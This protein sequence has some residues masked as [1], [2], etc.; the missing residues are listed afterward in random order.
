M[1]NREQRINRLPRALADRNS[2]VLAED[3]LHLALESCPRKSRPL[4]L[5][6]KQNNTPREIDIREGNVRGCRRSA[7]AVALQAELRP[8]II[9]S[10]STST[11]SSFSRDAPDQCTGMVLSLDCLP[12]EILHSILCYC[13]PASAAAL[14]Q[15]ARRFSSITDDPILWRFYCQAYFQL[16]DTKHELPKKL[17]SPVASVDWKTLYTR[18]HRID[19]QV[20]RLLDSILETEHGRIGKFQ[21]VIAFGYDTQDT[22]LR[23]ASVGPGAEDV[24]ARRF[25]LDIYPW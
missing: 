8:A 14:A 3:P 10:A 11:A 2:L 25:A 13:P 4:K 21:E 12:Q 7:R 19:R 22:L 23:H 1:K 6:N 24:L 15:T 16:W 9:T 17:A 18:R 20:S 5:P